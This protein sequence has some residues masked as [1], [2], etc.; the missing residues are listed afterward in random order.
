LTL[1]V[2]TLLT[3]TQTQTVCTNQLPY[4]WYGHVFNAAGSLIDTVASTTGGCDTLRTLTLTV[5]SNVTSTF[6][7]IGP[8]CQN[9][10]APLFPGISNNGIAGTWNP[11]TINTLTPGTNN[12][13]FT[14]TGGCAA[15]ATMNIVITPQITPAFTQIGLICQNSTAPLLPGTSNNG[16]TGTWS[17]ATINT[18]IA[19]TFAFR[20]TPDSSQCATILDLNLTIQNAPN[21]VITDP[22]GV[23][24][25]ATVNLTSAN[26]TA[27]SDAGL[28]FTYWTNPTATISLSNPT[29][30]STS[31]TYYIKATNSA[32][33]SKIDS[34]RVTVHPPPIVNLSGAG[35]ICAGSG[36]VITVALTGTGP[37]SFT[38]TDGVKSTTVGPINSNSYQINVSPD[39]TTTYTV[40]NII[41]A[42]CSSTGN[43]GTA[44][45][46]VLS[47][48]QSI[49]YP[50]VTTQTNTATQLT[51]R[52]LGSS[53]TYNWN[54]P[55]G[56][57]STKI[58]NPV[59]KYD[60]TTEYTI[61]IALDNGCTVVDTLLVKVLPVQAPINEDLWVP[62]GWTPN[63]D[64]HNDKLYPLT[65]NIKE[66]RFFRI[67]NR[68]GEI[69]FETNILGQGWD[70]IYKG[71]P[72]VIDVYTWT[73]EGVGISGRVIRKSGNSILI[74]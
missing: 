18:A 63:G 25:P 17:P 55:V 36:T 65:L 24:S 8:L 69:V 5:N 50:T 71:K 7:Q 16:I 48:V 43:L 26:I 62:K 31:G 12:Y 66:L 57:N 68:W 52:N 56:L 11:A 3:S 59:F 38:Y 70:G 72:Q 35:T 44:V 21:L 27:G 45:I 6:A 53:Y 74:R 64:G 29:A 47:P 40:N 46:S 37:F 41:D 49:R 42:Y 2:S 22:A 51:A 33:C 15:A 61:N 34:V 30:V 14:P 19:G 20:F 4:I 67:F 58:I 54:P 23:C 28:I 60:R 10:I 73:A 9:S 1:T 39:S 13:T 32:G